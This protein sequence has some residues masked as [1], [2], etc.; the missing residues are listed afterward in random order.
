M[1]QRVTRDVFNA[2]ITTCVDGDGCCAAACDAASDSDCIDAGGPT[3]GCNVTPPNGA[4]LMLL[5]GAVG[6][7]GL[8][9]TAEFD[10]RHSRRCAK[11]V[12]HAPRWHSSPLRLTR[13][14]LLRAAAEVRVFGLVHG[15]TV[16]S[17]NGPKR[18]RPREQWHVDSRR[19]IANACGVM[20]RDGKHR[21]EA[22]EHDCFSAFVERAAVDLIAAH[23][24]AY[25]TN[26][27]IAEL[28]FD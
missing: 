18:C 1:P 23:G 9:R 28:G 15:Q 19:P 26:A 14:E 20:P 2:T 24:G 21:A 13:Y 27:A 17:Q 12:Q 4:P 7:L 5:L 25:D 11:T 8:R 22:T 3:G 10:S 6:W 16:N